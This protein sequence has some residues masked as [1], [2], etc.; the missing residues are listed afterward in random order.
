MGCEWQIRN[1]RRSPLGHWVRQPQISPKS[2]IPWR[3]IH[4]QILRDKNRSHHSISGVEQSQSR[5][6]NFNL[7]LSDIPPPTEKGF[8][9]ESARLAIFR[10]CA[11]SGKF[12]G[13]TSQTEILIFFARISL[14]QNLGHW[15]TNIPQHKRS[16]FVWGEC[17]FAITCYRKSYSV[18]LFPR[19]GLVLFFLGN[20][21]CVSVAVTVFGVLS[22][23]DWNLSKFV[24]NCRFSNFDKFLTNFS[25]PDW[26][27]A[28]TIVGTNFGQIWCFGVFLNAVR[29][30]S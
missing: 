3:P 26:N 22:P 27:P 11:I 19:T 10:G 15:A 1:L 29:G 12:L 20:H 23:G 18:T 30:K 24:R 8:G 28:K 14:G 5:Y 6:E 13:R 7:D 2:A 21:E 4:P 9:G 16:A 17:I 25:P